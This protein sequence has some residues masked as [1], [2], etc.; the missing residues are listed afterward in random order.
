MS[1]N[2]PGI[3]LAGGAS[4]PLG[5]G[6]EFVA[7]GQEVLVTFEFRNLLGPG[8]YFLNAGVLGRVDE[9]G[10]T[11]L[12]RVL[13]AMMFRVEAAPDAVATGMVNLLTDER[14]QVR[15]LNAGDKIDASVPK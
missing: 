7:E 8:T 1:K 5:E 15:V 9:T 11:W 4:H 14:C 6:L 13:D 12:H 3:E 10:E 2:V